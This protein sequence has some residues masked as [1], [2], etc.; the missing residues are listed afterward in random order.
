MLKMT[1]EINEIMDAGYAM[2]TE[3]Y[4][5]RLFDLLLKNSM[6]FTGAD[7]GEIFVTDKNRFT[8]FI[9]IN[10]TLDNKGEHYDPIEEYVD[11]RAMNMV[12]YAVSHKQVLNIDDLYV[13]KQ[14]ETLKIKE[15][16]QLHDYKTKSVMVIPIYELDNKVIG[17]MRLI[18]CT[19][20]D[21]SI[22]SF[23]AEYEKMVF[24]LTSQMSISL[25]NMQKMQEMDELLG[26]FVKSMTTAI[27]ARTPYNGNHTKNVAKYCEEVVEYMN[28][29]HTRGEFREFISEEDKVQLLMAARL[30]DLGKMITPRE[31]LNKATRLGT[32]YDGLVARLEKIKLL[33]KIDMLEGRLD[34]AEWTMEDLRLTN[35]LSELPQLNIKGRLSESEVERIK[36]MGTKVYTDPEGKDFEYL[37]IDEVKSL[38]IA[39][40][41]LTAEE[42]NI[43]EQHVVYTDKMLAEIKFNEKYNRVRKIASCHHEY[44]DGTGYPNHLRAEDLDMLTRILTIVDIYD[45]LTST[46]RPYKGMVP[47]DKAMKILEEMAHEGKLDIELVGIINDCMREHEEKK[48]KEPFF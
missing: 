11:I 46:D 13:E 45:S 23:P 19:D 20:D 47:P 15:F 37:T 17:V 32:L 42:R 43:V 16:D 36:Y 44:L 30:H 35:F 25:T 34:K 4:F 26:S 48:A 2:A 5:Q 10:K 24:S 41:T 7:S 9:H 38:S 28:M 18:N 31:V 14:F 33:L 1:D 27:D 39:K 29:L 3:K 21:G 6:K 12:T 22:V 40:G 8:A